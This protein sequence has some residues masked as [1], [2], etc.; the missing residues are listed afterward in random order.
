MARDIVDD[1]LI[2]ALHVRALTRNGFEHDPAVEHTAFQIGTLDALM[3]GR[4]DG[5]A[6]VGELLEHGD[7][8]I[9]TVEH[10]GG[11]LVV[12]DGRAVVVDGDGLV[13]DVAPSTR[14][15][16]AVVVRFAPLVERRLEGPVGL[17]ELHRELDDMLP[18]DAVVAVRVDGA[19]TDLRLR[20]VHTQHPPYPP[21]VEVTRHQR[22]W[23]VDSS[24]GTVVGF[25]FPVESLGT[26]VPGHHLHFVADDRSSGGHVLDLTMQH[27]TARLDAGDELHVELPPEVQLGEP[28]A[29]DRAAIRQAEGG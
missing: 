11:E 25:R 28:G 12:L 10:L 15:P 27:G 2:G 8:G 29:A 22:E 21:L 23:M 5:D 3:A 24:A 18:A 14:T 16:F 19:F 9:G 4:Y 20:S 6:T 7:L 1:R 13:H 17:D 26:E